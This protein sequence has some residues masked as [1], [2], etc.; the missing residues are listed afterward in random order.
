MNKHYIKLHLRILSIAYFIA[1]TFLADPAFAQIKYG[2]KAGLNFSELP[3][4]T[5]YIINQQI[6]NGYHFGII[7][8]FKLSGKLFLQPGLLISNKGSEYIVGNNT[9]GN[10]TGFS[11]FQFS[12]FYADVPVNLAYKIGRA[13]YKFL[14]LAGP[15]IGYGLTGKWEATYGTESDVHFGNGPEDDLKP[16]DYGVNIGAGLEAGRFQISSQYY[17]GLRTLSTVTPP[18]EEQKYKVLTIS[19]A[20][21]FG[22]DQKLYMDYESRYL[23]KH[24]RNKTHR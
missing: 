23:R 15:Q 14:L 13:S 1:F 22:K 12:A 7:S 19:I 20:Y 10:T 3:N 17:I 2:P 9:G 5:E 16:F 8:E 21:L 4:Y 6:Y 24:S 18:L 11:N